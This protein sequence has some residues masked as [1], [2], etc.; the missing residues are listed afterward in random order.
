MSP[1]LTVLTFCTCTEKEWTRGSSD[2]DTR[3]ART[4]MDHRRNSLLKCC[5]LAESMFRHP[6]N[7][8]FW[9][10]CK[11]VGVDSRVPETHML[12]HESCVRNP[13][14]RMLDLGI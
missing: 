10:R 7:T 9:T 1:S 3:R 2:G 8:Y 11:L 4:A 5:C 12:A 14:K 6:S 13:V